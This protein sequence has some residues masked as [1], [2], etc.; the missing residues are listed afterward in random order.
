MDSMA[1]ALSPANAGMVKVGLL[2][3]VYYFYCYCWV[4]KRIL[5]KRWYKVLL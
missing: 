4:T 1:A 3:K 2:K 5:T